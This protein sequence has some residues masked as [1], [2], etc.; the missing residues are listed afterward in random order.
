[1]KKQIKCELILASKNAVT[2][3]VIYTFKQ[4]FPKF[5]L[6]ETLTHSV[7]VKNTA[8]SRAI[9]TLRMIKDVLNDPVRPISIGSYQSGMQSGAEITGLRRKILEQ[10]WSVSRYA[11]AGVA[12]LAYRLGAAKQFTNRL[13]E[14]WVW[15][16]QISTCTDVENEILLRD[17][18]D[19]EPH[20][21]ELAR[22][23]ALII[24]KVKDTFD[25]DSWYTDVSGRCQVLEIGQ[26]HLPFQMANENIEELVNITGLSFIEIQKRLSV[27]RCAWVSY[28]MPGTKKMANTQAALHTYAKL[29]VN[30]PRHLSPAQHVATPLPE[31]VR[32]GPFCGWLMHR[33]EIEGES[34]G[35][36]VVPSITPEQA[37]KMLDEY[38]KQHRNKRGELV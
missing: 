33:K 3:D 8:S 25:N 18:E 38:T 13:L 7:I 10:L 22:Q 5:I 34:G 29:I 17:H 6:A 32:V 30:E 35:D 15:T 14:P 12:L 1:M 31:S 19:A 21:H 23:K 4:T 37:F 2:G 26:W 28:F 9:P 24:Q 20:Y 36:K 27:A 11:I 16:E